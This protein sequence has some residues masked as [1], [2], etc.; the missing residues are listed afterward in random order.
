MVIVAHLKPD[1][2][3]A[4]TLLP[5]VKGGNAGSCMH[6]STG[7]ASVDLQIWTLMAVRESLLYTAAL[8][9]VLW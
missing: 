6:V 7:A 8:D 5:P 4:L 9:R 2:K 1:M 3:S